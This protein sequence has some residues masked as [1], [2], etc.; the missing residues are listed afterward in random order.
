MRDS[1]AFISVDNICNHHP[2][3]VPEHFHHAKEYPIPISSRSHFHPLQLLATTN[4]FCGFADVGHF[5][6][7]LSHDMWHFVAGFFHLAKGVRV[8]SFLRSHLA[9]MGVKWF[10]YSVIACEALVTHSHRLSHF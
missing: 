6:C 4:S 3:L 5:Y 10:R 9:N 8:P 1:V 7:M 2:Y